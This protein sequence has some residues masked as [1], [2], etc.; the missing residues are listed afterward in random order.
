MKILIV[1]D[2]KVCANM[3]KIELSKF[4]Q[5]DIV[6]DGKTALKTFK[7][8]L[9]NGKP[10]QL[11]ILDIVLPDI[12]GGEVLKIVR[13]IEEE[14]GIAYLDK[15][16]IVVATAYDDWYNRKIIIDK[17]NYEYET[18]YIK[19]PDVNELIDKIIDLGFVLE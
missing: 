13:G 3:Y 11:M 16:R 7:E 14:I 6:N 17:L 1:E 4:G 2:D 19:S 10:Y 8:A 9:E 15:L 12:D 18:F 5:C